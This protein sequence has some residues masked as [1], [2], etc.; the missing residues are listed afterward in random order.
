MRKACP[1]MTDSWDHETD[2]LVLGSGAAGLGAA[3]VGAQEGLGV[4][5]LEKT[6]WLGGTTA[7]SAGT[8]W[9]P[10]HRHQQDPAA[11]TEA[12]RGYLDTLIGDRAPR[13]LRESYLAHGP[14]MLDYLDKQLGVGFW[15]S[16]AVVDYH[17][18]IP[19]YGV[20][21]ALE[22][23]TVDGR[24]LGRAGFARIRPPV[25]EFALLGG[26][27]MVRR[28][29]ADQLLGIFNGSPRGIA[30]ALRLGLRWA[31]DRAA[32]WPRGTRLAMGNAL[33]A[34][35]YRQ[36]LRRRGDI[37]FTAHATEL[38]AD[39]TD[40]VIGAVVSHQG[41]TLRI[42]ARNGVV[43][44]TGGFPAAPELRSAHLPMP[45]PHHTRAVES[46]TGDSFALARAVGGTLG[47]PDGDNALWFPSSIGRRRDGSPV[48]FPHI[49]DRAKPGIIAVDAA[50]RRFTDESASYHHFVRA[51]YRGQ[52]SRPTIPAWLVTD[53]HALKK[54]GLG[55]VRPH[56]GRRSLARHIASG[57]LCTGR[58]LHDLAAAAGIDA[59]GLER[60]VADCNRSARTGAD[61]YFGRGS[62]PYGRQF[63]DPDHAPNVNLG[64]IEKAPFYALTVVPT[65]LATSL[66]LRTNAKAQVLDDD[67]EPIRGLYACGNDAG[68]MAASEYPGAGCQIGSG[69]VFG[70]LAA[71]HAAA[72]EETR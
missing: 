16:R 20:G 33:V 41:R 3:A 49:W 29:E 31:R 30:L 37:W 65:P 18:E 5:V 2:L 39:A 13:S 48:V 12:A 60:T 55:L 9:I 42:G 15:H 46:A 28:P 17:P 25:P 72:V 38:I 52:A 26:T 23:H 10:G 43:L 54:Y 63:G 51:M 1:R 24:V 6:E 7:Y 22:P 50:G 27:L 66:G 34:Q 45:T 64:P 59:H 40:C 21:R 19:G 4:L 69:L 61:E 35:L 11:D 56:A 32:G 62:S 67:D 58:T 14:E 53:S 8:A 71:R 44:A 57:Y 70:Y 36:L 68:S 47:A